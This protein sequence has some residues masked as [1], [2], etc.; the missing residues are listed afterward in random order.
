MD[1]RAEGLVV[2]DGRVTTTAAFSSMYDFALGLVREHDG[3]DVARGTARLAL[4]DD[5]RSSQTPY[6]DPSMLPTV[7][8]DFSLTVKRWLDQNLHAR[9]DL[10]A[11]AREFH[12]STRTLLRRFGDEAGQ[13]PL[14]YLQGARVVRARYLLESTDK[15]VARIA[16]E[17]GY[18]D[19]ST[20]GLIFARH[21]GRRPREY[22]TMFRTAARESS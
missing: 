4:V 12:V 22:R 19:A 14:E 6:V 15:P 10:S 18:A 21:T 11:L 13:S 7:G 5:A 16:A 3:P 9:Y 20:F 2:T 8:H 17:V 1:V